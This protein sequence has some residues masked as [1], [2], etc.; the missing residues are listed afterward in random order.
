[1]TNIFSWLFDNISSA[2]I[3]ALL[4]A[5]LTLAYLC[6]CARDER[7]MALQNAATAIET[8]KV[9]KETIE[10]L[11]AEIIKRDELA[12]IWQEELAK[13]RRAR[14]SVHEELHELLEQNGAAR[15]WSRHTV[16]DSIWMRLKDSADSGG[17]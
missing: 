3:V 7:D 1:M 16:P 14:D 6:K 9:N 10:T 12:A 4:V 13:E 5:C 8:N 11:E 2:L 15:D 17:N